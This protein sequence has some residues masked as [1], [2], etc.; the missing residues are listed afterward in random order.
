[1]RAADS[2]AAV[3]RLAAKREE[4]GADDFADYAFLTLGLLGWQAPEVL[5]F[6]LDRADAATAPEEATDA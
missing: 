3:E 6:L 4:L 5:T 2:E 1:M